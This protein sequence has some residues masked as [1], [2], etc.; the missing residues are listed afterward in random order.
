MDGVTKIERDTFYQIMLHCLPSG[1]G[2]GEKQKRQ[3]AL[4]FRA[5]SWDA[6][7]HAVLFVHRVVGLPKGLYFLVR[8]EDHL[9]ELKKST[10]AEFKWEK[11]EGCPV[12]LPLY[13]LARS[14]CQQIAKQLSCHQV[15]HYL[16]FSIPI[17]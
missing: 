15:C 4:P 13:E 12:D 3:L 8:N 5:L 2:S 10:R 11:P 7:V 1:C 6:E 14:D 17:S 16:T 9:D